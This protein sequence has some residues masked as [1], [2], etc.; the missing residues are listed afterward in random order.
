M[1]TLA[2]KVLICLLTEFI[3]FPQNIRSV[4]KSVNGDQ[5]P[6]ST[7]GAPS[8]PQGNHNQPIQDVDRTIPRQPKTPNRLFNPFNTV[9]KVSCFISI[10]YVI[11][12]T[13]TIVRKHHLIYYY[14]RHGMSLKTALI[15]LNIC[16][17]ST[18]SILG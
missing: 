16:L 9:H 2:N 6:I 7:E 1:F 13:P 12:W 10:D 14:V 17:K 5:D 15:C 8:T 3:L 11:R 18:T 4:K